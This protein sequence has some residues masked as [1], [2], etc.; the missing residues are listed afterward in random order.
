M[1]Q[2]SLEQQKLQLER[3]CP[4]CG[5]D[6]QVEPH[7]LCCDN[8]ELS[9]HGSGYILFFCLEKLAF[10]ICLALAALSIYKLYV[11]LDGKYCISVDDPVYKAFLSAI[12]VCIKDWITIHSVANYGMQNKNDKLL[13]IAFFVILL[14]FLA[15]YQVYLKKI[16]HNADQGNDVPSDWTVVVSFIRTLGQRS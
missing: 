7:S 14:L 5:L 11:N 12:N 16:S 4:C 9:D 3:L 10:I 6:P 2:L 13:M 1:S 8:M 15:Y